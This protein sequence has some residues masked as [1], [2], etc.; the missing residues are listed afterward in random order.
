MQTIMDMDLSE[1][2]SASPAKMDGLE[3]IQFHVKTLVKNLYTQRISGTNLTNIFTSDGLAMLDGAKYLKR[4][5][6]LECSCLL[7]LCFIMV[8]M[9]SGGQTF[10]EMLYLTNNPQ[11]MTHIAACLQK[12]RQSLNEAP[13]AD[14]TAALQAATKAHGITFI[15][16]VDRG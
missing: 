12:L 10:T 2:T 16:G 5:K 14:C 13:R 3:Q 11:G 15:R 7:E 6:H 4:Y 1:P 8:G 9:E